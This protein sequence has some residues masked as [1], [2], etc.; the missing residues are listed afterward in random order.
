MIHRYCPNQTRRKGTR[1]R[2]HTSS[3]MRPSMCEAP[4]KGKVR[5]NKNYLPRPGLGLGHVPDFYT[6]FR[7]CPWGASVPKPLM[8][9]RGGS[10]QTIH[11]KALWSFENRKEPNKNKHPPYQPP[12]ILKRCA[13]RAPAAPR[14]ASASPPSRRSPDRLPEPRTGAFGFRVSGFS[15]FLIKPFSRFGVWGLGVLRFVG[16]RGRPRLSLATFAKKVGWS[17]KLSSRLHFSPVFSVSGRLRLPVSSER[18]WHHCTG[19]HSS[20]D[21]KAGYHSGMGLDNSTGVCDLLPK[22][23]LKKYRSLAM[24]PMSPCTGPGRRSRSHCVSGLPLRKHRRVPGRWPT[25]LTSHDP[26]LLSRREEDRETPEPEVDNRR[27]LAREVF[28]LGDDGR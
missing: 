16:F 7:D 18:S 11:K 22:P 17:R 12:R 3:T 13:R 21:G 27:F 25:V 28:E 19:Q 4:E 23:S 15:A 14:R 8:G 24:P 10:P 5:M 9:P 1:H 2:V 6:R 20:M 26:L